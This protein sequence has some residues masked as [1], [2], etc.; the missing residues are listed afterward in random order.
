MFLEILLAILL[1]VLAGCFTGLVPGVH[2]NLVATFVIAAGVSGNALPFIV[3][4]AITHS[5]INVIPGILLGAPESSTAL[6]VLPGHRY[7]LNGHGLMAIKLT[8]V[9]SYF[10]LLIALALIP[11]W[12][13]ILKLYQYFTPFIGYAI[14]LV[15][16]Y[17]ILRDNKRVWAFS[18][19]M[20]SGVLGY[21]LLNKAL[22]QEP[23][24]P[25]L[26]GL[27]GTATLLYSM[28]ENQTIPPQQ[29]STEIQ[30]KKGP[31]LQALLAGNVAGFFTSM[32]PGLGN[33]QAAI[34]AMTFTRKIGDHGFLIL[35]G[36]ID[37][38]NFSLSLLTW[39]ALDRARNGA[40]VAITTLAE[41]EIALVRTL[42]FTAVIT[43][44][45]AVPLCLLLSRKALRIL[46]ILPYR[47]TCI[48]VLALITILV[49]FLTGWRGLI[50]LI[51]ATG[52]GL[53][54]AIKKCGRAHAMGCLLLPV[55][56]Y[57]L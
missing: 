48:A 42:L 47:N 34:L 57:F 56:L 4:L 22:V 32:L 39:L 24:F 26:S 20:L 41:P 3:S 18:V 50:V 33:A 13:N 9:G 40:I 44:S 38:I 36:A 51:T 21:L 55:A 28:N 27:F 25:L 14:I 31:T 23:L 52:I 8:V 53:I 11:V 45:I 49:L 35:I 10:G 30:L 2:V 1:G 54:P 29:D 15:S 6:G 43:A 7:L 17:L 46:S 37:T 5:I 16:A 12:W 19:Y